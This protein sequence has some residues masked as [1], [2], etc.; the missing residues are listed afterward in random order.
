[1]IK[2]RAKGHVPSHAKSKYHF[3]LP[4]ATHLFYSDSD[5]ENLAIVNTVC[6]KIMAPVAIVTRN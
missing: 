3:L 6:P 5:N 4:I 2:K 1:M